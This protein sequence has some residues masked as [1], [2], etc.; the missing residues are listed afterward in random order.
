MVTLPCNSP[1]QINKVHPRLLQL[2]TQ[3]P[4]VLGCLA[5]GLKFDGVHFDA[6]DEGWVCDATADFGDDFEDYSAAVGEGAAI[7]VGAF[8]GCLGEELG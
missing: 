5:T 4:T 8:V 6:D 7:G 2:H 3:L 1:T